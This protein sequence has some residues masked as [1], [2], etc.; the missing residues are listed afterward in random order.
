[1]EGRSNGG[2]FA[3]PD[4]GGLYLEGLIFGILRYVRTLLASLGVVIGQNSALQWGGGFVWS[5][6]N[7]HPFN[8][9]RGAGEASEKYNI[10]PILAIT[11]PQPP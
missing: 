5:K 8:A 11:S 1:M 10:R 3:L 9:G 6:A 4:W 2:F 7:I